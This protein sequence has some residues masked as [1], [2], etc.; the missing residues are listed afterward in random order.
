MKQNLQLSVSLIPTCYYR[1]K[2]EAVLFMQ[3]EWYRFSNSTDVYLL[4][5]YIVEDLKNKMKYLRN[6]KPKNTKRELGEN[7]GEPKAKKER[8]EPKHLPRKPT[9]VPEMPI[10]EDLESCERN[11]KFLQKEE[12]KKVV[13]Q[14]IIENL[15]QCTLWESQ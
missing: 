11:I 2:C 13:N 6:A 4:Q 12:K 9:E 14:C 5:G 3:P 7:Q 10:G 15:M 1:N 8:V